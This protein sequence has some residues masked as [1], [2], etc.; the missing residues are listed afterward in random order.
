[1]LLR[2]TACFSYC[3]PNDFQPRYSEWH[4]EGQNAP[5]RDFGH[6]TSKFHFFNLMQTIIEMCA[7]LVIRDRAAV[8]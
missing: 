5:V 2:L 1:M 4:P 7:K 6:M 3:I 8:S